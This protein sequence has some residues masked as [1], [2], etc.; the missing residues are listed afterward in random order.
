MVWSGLRA[1]PGLQSRWKRPD[2]G[3]HHWKRLGRGRE[4]RGAHRGLCAWRSRAS[5]G[6]CGPTDRCLLCVPGWGRGGATW[7]AAWAGRAV[8]SPGRGAR[9]NSPCTSLFGA[10]RPAAVR[11]RAVSAGASA[12]GAG[13]ARPSGSPS[14]SP[15]RPATPGLPRRPLRTR[16]PL[17][18]AAPRTR[19]LAFLLPSLSG[20]SGGPPRPRRVQAGGRRAVRPGWRPPRHVLGPRHQQPLPA[21]PP[22]LEQRLRAA[23]EGAA[24]PGE[25]RGAESGS[26]LLLSPGIHRALTVDRARCR[27]LLV[28]SPLSDIVRNERLLFHLTEKET[29]T[30][31]PTCL[32]QGARPSG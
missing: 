13:W 20:R 21:A 19:P 2:C 26:V 24:G 12:R 22:G 14:R 23:G 9:W 15:A 17:S 18:P 29:E 32:A 11:S 7:S 28:H 27:G 4:S 3:A 6:P 5:R 1:H 10:V 30:P 31:E 8:A 16:R 25:V